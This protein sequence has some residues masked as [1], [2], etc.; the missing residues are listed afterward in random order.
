MT[1]IVLADDHPVVRLGIKAI[2]ETDPDFFVVGEA[3]NGIVANQL[4]TQLKPDILITDLSMP[5]MNGL[6][7]VRSLQQH[8]PNVRIII[9]SMHEDE[10][11]AYK[12]FQ[13]GADAYVFKQ[14]SASAIVQ[15][16][17]AVVAGHRGVFACY[18]GQ[19]GTYDTT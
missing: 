19:C 9:I 13:Y 4:V 17:H 18:E 14:A 2:L 5:G 3:S 16:V 8:M 7:L 10:E 15:T 6:E 1:T 11:Y 12:A